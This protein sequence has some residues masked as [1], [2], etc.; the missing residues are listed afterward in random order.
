MIHRRPRGHP[1]S[2]RTTATR[3]SGLAPLAAVVLLGAGCSLS[4]DVASVASALVS[5]R[6]NIEATAPPEAAPRASASARPQRPDD[7][8]TAPVAGD[9]VPPEMASARPLVLTSSVPV[10]LR[11]PAIGVDTELV[12]L[13]LEADGTMEV[14]AGAFP[15]GWYTGAPTPGA[16]GPAVIAGHVDWAG[17]AGVFAALDELRA[18]DGIAVAREDGTTAVFDVTK[19]QRV[20]KRAFPTAAV[21]GDLDHAGLRLITC[22][23]A[24]DRQA[25]SYADNFIVF[26]EL[27]DAVDD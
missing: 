27:R 24:F 18:G 7:G 15:A 13:G 17:S 10:R 11:I 1:R 20:A 19:V 5:A 8:E 3:A 9:D 2:G 6:S 25:G 22:G 16:L 4:A 26:A 21:Y 12:D 23:G 14:P